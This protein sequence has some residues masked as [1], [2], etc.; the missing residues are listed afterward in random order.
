VSGCHRL[1]EPAAVFAIQRCSQFDRQR[2]A[3][4][5]K[6]AIDCSGRTSCLTGVIRVN[7]LSDSPSSVLMDEKWTKHFEAYIEAFG[8]DRCMFESDFPVDRRV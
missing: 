3:K 5:R 7:Q 4:F 8:S 2:E 6:L 1:S